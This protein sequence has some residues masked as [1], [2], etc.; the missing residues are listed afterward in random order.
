MCAVGAIHA[1]NHTHVTGLYVEGGDRSV[2]EKRNPPEI[3]AL[4]LNALRTI[5]KYANG[6]KRKSLAEGATT[7][8]YS[9]EHPS[10]PEDHRELRL[11]SADR[12]YAME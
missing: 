11:S 10:L 4:L 6:R 1:W 12:S 5:I 9:A 2:G 3:S 8:L 7:A